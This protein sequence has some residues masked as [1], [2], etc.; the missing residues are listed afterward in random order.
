MQ[1]RDQEFLGVMKNR[2]NRAICLQSQAHRL[3]YGTPI[4]LSAWHRKIF[5]PPV[6]LDASNELHTQPLFFSRLM[7][8]PILARFL[9]LFM[10]AIFPIWV[11]DKNHL[12]FIV[13][14]WNTCILPN[15]LYSLWKNI[16]SF[17]FFVSLQQKW[18]IIVHIP[19][20][21]NSFSLQKK[22]EKKIGN[23]EGYQEQKL[24][25]KSPKVWAHKLRA[26]SSN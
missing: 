2:R 13:P 12:W 4:L 23:Q 22:E 9:V 18:R 11:K 1:R 3:S 15:I 21:N 7:Y 17:N 26:K 10:G 24:K 16:F 5:V 8:R 20:S 25:C 6:L 14:L 19:W